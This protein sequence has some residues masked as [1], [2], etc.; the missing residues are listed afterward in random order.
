[1]VDCN[2]KRRTAQNDYKG[3]HFSRYLCQPDVAARERYRCSTY[4][5]W[6]ANPPSPPPCHHFGCVKRRI[7]LD[8]NSSS[9][10]LPR[11]KVV[12]VYVVLSPS[13]ETRG[14]VDTFEQNQ[15]EADIRRMEAQLR[16][17]VRSEDE[18]GKC[19]GREKLQPL[20]CGLTCFED[21]AV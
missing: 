18:I 6:R 2:N 14:E 9:S 13:T 7:T 15:P 10:S 21:A 12:R 20:S 16:C 11:S 8:K 3:G 1:M 19:P 17:R 5:S 4:S